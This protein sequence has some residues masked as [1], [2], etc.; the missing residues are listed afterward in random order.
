MK[1]KTFNSKE[2]E[3]LL[4]EYFSADVANLNS[5]VTIELGVERPKNF[6]C[7]LFPFLFG[8]GSAIPY[9]R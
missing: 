2:K 3:I 1:K 7:R 9:R 6:G 4:I 8:S 5:T